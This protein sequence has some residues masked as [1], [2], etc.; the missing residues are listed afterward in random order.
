[1]GGSRRS[2]GIA[3]IDER[4]SGQTYRCAVLLQK[5]RDILSRAWRC[6]RIDAAKRIAFGPA[7]LII[8]ARSFPQNDLLL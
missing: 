2:C 1:M 3:A 5:N 6:I 7:L 4:V 8:A